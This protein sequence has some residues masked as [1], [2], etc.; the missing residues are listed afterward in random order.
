M[1]QIISIIT[2]II[3][4]VLFAASIMLIGLLAAILI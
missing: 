4:E 2:G 1:K 3:S